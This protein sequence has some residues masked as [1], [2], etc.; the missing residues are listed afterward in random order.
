MAD[1]SASAAP[2]QPSAE[3]LLQQLSAFAAS[4]VPRL[5][6][7]EAAVT[8]LQSRNSG[9]LKP[10]KP[11]SFSGLDK[12]RLAIH[13]WTCAV[14]QYFDAT[15]TRADSERIAYASCLL[16]GP[17]L[18][19]WRD[20][21]PLQRPGTWTNFVQAIIQYFLPAG[22]EESGRHLLSRLAHRTSVADYTDR[23]RSIAATIPTM[24]DAEKLHAY[25]DGLKR[26]V[27]LL[28][29]FSNPA[30]FEEC[31]ATAARVD[32]ILFHNG[33]RSRRDMP[34]TRGGSGGPPSSLPMPM[35]LGALHRNSGGA[36]TPLRRDDNDQQ[37]LARLTDRERERL[38][39]IGACF[40]CR[41]PGHMT[42]EC[43]LN[44][45]RQQGN[46]QRRQ[47]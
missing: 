39:A 28:V 40:R 30:T 26:E 12:E 16:R 44:D 31:V 45:Q 4:T 20:T 6:G 24:S 23:F 19:W 15:G 32:D 27:R 10:P 22:A 25:T 3:E 21:P 34:R 42:R 37:R 41:Q 33:A 1:P 47:Q 5:Q 8:T 35:D 2:A 18:R 38:R 17:A 29:T 36:R 43:P 13:D 46:G 7:L 9:K 14:T 11:E